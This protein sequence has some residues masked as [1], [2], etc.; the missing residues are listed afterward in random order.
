MGRNRRRIGWCGGRFAWARRGVTVAAAV[1]LLVLLTG[2]AAWAGGRRLGST[3]SALSWIQ[4]RDTHGVSVWCYE[5]SIDRGGVTSPGKLIWSYQI[6]FFWQVYRSG[7]VVAIWLIDWVLS[8]DWL[9]RLATPALAMSRNLHAMVGR[10]GLGPVLLTAAATAAVV[11]MARGKWALGIVE[12]FTSLLI[13]SLAMGMLAN[14]VG[15]VVG[16]RGVIMQSRDF[17]MRVAGV[18]AADGSR[19]LDAD[20][21][22][23]HTT[24]MLVD[25]FIRMPSQLLNFGQVL[26]GGKCAKPYDAAVRAGPYGTGS[27]I[28]DAVGRCDPALGAVA[29]NPGSGQAISGLIISPAALFVLLFAILLAG[30]VFLA[31]V[32]ALYQALRAVVTLVT[33]LLPGPARATC[34]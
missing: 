15:S 25:T 1:P 27:A 23:A 31:A 17:G 22:R 7:V 33:G 12:L 6:D 4:L 28:R 3:P 20:Q 24:G 16:N 32:Y 30:S 34:W 21:L 13:A 10:F 14:P 5:M 26:D 11:W 9:A 19:V 8:F 2:S 18:L 29:A